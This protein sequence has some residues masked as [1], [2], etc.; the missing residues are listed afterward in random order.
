MAVQ[1]WKV[2][3]LGVIFYGLIVTM[4]CPWGNQAIAQQ[5]L[6]KG[7]RD[8]TFNEAKIDADIQEVC[9]QTD[10]LIVIKRNNPI[11]VWRDNQ[12]LVLAWLG[13]CEKKPTPTSIACMEEDTEVEIK[14]NNNDYAIWV[15]AVP[16]IKDFLTKQSAASPVPKLRDRLKKYLGLDTRDSYDWFVEIWV[17]KDSLIRPCVNTNIEDAKC[18]LISSGLALDSRFNRARQRK[19]PFTGLGYSYDWGS[20]ESDIG[21]SEFAIKDGAKVRIRRIMAT[22]DYIRNSINE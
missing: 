17:D 10:R 21:A 7:E 16:E 3:K 9:E 11:L 15:T 13:P 12:V 4:L 22:D 18:N 6:S 5:C 19:W 20:R 14:G 1:T 8:Q 2:D